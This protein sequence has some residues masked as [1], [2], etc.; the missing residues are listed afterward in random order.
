MGDIN[1]INSNA[2]PQVQIVQASE[3]G[4]ASSDEVKVGH[5]GARTVKVVKPSANEVKDANQA[6]AS[7][8]DAFLSKS[9]EI[10]RKINEY[11]AKQGQGAGT[12]EHGS[13]LSEEINNRVS[14]WLDTI[15]DLQDEGVSDEDIGKVGDAELAEMMKLV[16]EAF[17]QPE[18]TKAETKKAE[19]QKEEA[20]KAESTTTTSQTKAVEK[21]P[22]LKE[23]SRKYAELAA[24][25]LT[26][27]TGK[28]VDSAKTHV[29][30]NIGGGSCF[31]H[32]VLQLLAKCDPTKYPVGNTEPSANR[33]RT[34]L[35]DHFKEVKANVEKG[36]ALGLQVSYSATN[37]KKV[38]NVLVKTSMS[39]ALE[40]IKEYEATRL[41]AMHKVIEGYELAM[42]PKFEKYET[43]ADVTTGAFMADLLKRPVTVIMQN[44]AAG[45][46]M[47][48]QEFEYDL[49]SGQKLE[50]EPLVIYYTG[51][52]FM[53]VS[54]DGWGSEKVNSGG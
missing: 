35:I 19:P 20:T 8:V 46:N 3:I 29:Y 1:G 33:L 14:N 16:D 41:D 36:D 39:A 54:V 50:G 9:D 12:L 21:N 34:K 26:K 7:L 18:A 43:C 37:P 53:A 23:A 42:N 13:K 5:L 24:N 2:M 47:T 4:K 25:A 52:H 15:Q 49:T 32:S 51:N 48:W 10:G 44:D 40:G 45:Q 22:P 28:T 17:D 11:L 31:F 27:A 30:E 38:T 6:K